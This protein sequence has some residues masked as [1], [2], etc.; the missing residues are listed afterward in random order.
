MDQR[1]DSPANP[2]IDFPNQAGAQGLGGYTY[3]VCSC[4]PSGK[5]AGMNRQA[6]NGPVLRKSPVL[7]GQVEEVPVW[8]AFARGLGASA[9]E[10]DPR[11]R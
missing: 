5:R 8:A 9:K 2:S 1:H 10:A 11:A 4:A 3:R 7:I 6:I